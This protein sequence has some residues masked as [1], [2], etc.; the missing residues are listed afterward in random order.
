MNILLT[1][2]T[3]YLGSHL[4]EAFV[5]SGNKV[6]LLTRSNSNRCH[7]ANI[8]PGLAIYEMEQDGLTT[9]FQDI[10]FDAIVHTATCYGRF[11][12]LPVEVFSANTAWP[13]QLLE[14]AV[15][16]S[17][18]LFIN[19][20]TSLDRFINPYALSK[21]QFSEWGYCFAGQEKI[22]FVNVVLEHFYGPGDLES[23]F[24]TRIV[25][26]CLRN[27]PELRL[28]AGTQ[29]RDFICIDDVVAAYLL[30]L[31]DEIY[32]GPAF[33]EYGLGS[34]VTVPVHDLVVMVK[35]LTGSNIKL[36]FGAVPLRRN[37][38][39]DL[40]ADISGLQS[41]GWQPQVSLA[42]GLTQMIKE[43]KELMER[44]AI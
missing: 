27:E 21:K 26:S 38:I 12:E 18:P 29:R 42:D 1:G 17:T 9:A 39:M 22:R 16:A 15:A 11:G 4:A 37:E 13:L 35:S 32:S 33:Q 8:L 31:R 20:D 40:H 3:G 5:T 34:G 44:T 2:A 24:V 7:L 25:R 19:T 43:E 14:T 30:L 10:Q 36:N 23:K 41:L 6:A 28:T